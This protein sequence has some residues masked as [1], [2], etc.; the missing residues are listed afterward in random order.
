MLAVSGE[1]WFSDP[2][3]AILNLGQRHSSADINLSILLR[4][5]YQNMISHNAWSSTGTDQSA[6]RNV[7]STC[8]KNW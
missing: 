4:D 8:T 1:A 6:K 5:D 3:G 2:I 7:P